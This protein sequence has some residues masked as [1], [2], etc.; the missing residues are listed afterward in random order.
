MLLFVTTLI[1]MFISKLHFHK[2]VS[3]M[4]KAFMFDMKHQESLDEII[5]YI[6]KK[7]HNSKVILKIIFKIT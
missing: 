1:F 2:K 7:N 4:T 3:I 5:I 6:M